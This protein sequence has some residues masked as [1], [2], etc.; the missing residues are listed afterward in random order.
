M[1]KLPALFFFLVLGFASHLFADQVVLTNGDRLTGTIVKSDDKTLLIKTEFAGDVTVQWPAVAQ[2]QSSQPLHVTLSSGQ[3]LA[4][5][6]TTNEG[7]LAIATASQ[8]TVTEPKATVS[9]I[10]NDAEQTAYEKSLHPNLLHGWAGGL[11]LGFGLTRGNSETKN[12]SLAFLA[13]R[14]TSTDHIGMYVNS[15]FSGNDAVGAVPTTT[16]NAVQGG[17]RYDRDL[18][19][20]IFAFV[21]A[22]FQT[23]ELQEL[24]LR[25]ILGGGLG[26]HAIK[27]D[28]TTLDLLAGANYTREN[29][30]TFDRNLAALTFGEELTHNFGSTALTEKLY[31]FPDLSETGEYRG[32]F[33][34]GS[35][36]KISKWFGWQNSFSDIYV[37]NPPAGTRQNDLVFTTGLNISFTH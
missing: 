8:G 7:N 5:P 18:T 12:F 9:A 24:N 13:D 21:N 10:R 31:F 6:V 26:Y 16:A 37:S 23:D 17:I 25:S 22:D 3:T 32:A 20:R 30:D 28:K 15:I 4:G 33:T 11:N 1:G 19:K 35:V 36:T 29:Y 34:F 2:V 27:S 14:K